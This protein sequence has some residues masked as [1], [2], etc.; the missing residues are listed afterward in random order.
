MFRREG[1]NPAALAPDGSGDIN[2][3]EVRRVEE[4][5]HR[6]QIDVI[7]VYVVRMLPAQCADGLFGGDTDAGRLGAD[8]IML[9]IR[10]VPD[11]DHRH[12]EGGGLST[13]LQLRLGLMGEPVADPQRELSEFERRRFHP[14]SDYIATR[15]RPIL[16]SS[17]EIL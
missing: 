5:I 14:V 15:P 17:E 2:G 4:A 1:L 13:G 9:A 10:L 3:K 6:I 7:G 11:R 8:Y 12:A 16:Q